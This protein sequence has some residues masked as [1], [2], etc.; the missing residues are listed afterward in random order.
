MCDRKR[1]MRSIAR[2]VGISFGAV[3]SIQIDT[4]DMS[5]A[6]ARWVTRMLTDDQKRRLGW[7]FLGLLFHYEDDPGDF[8]KRVV[9]LDETRVHHFDP[10]PKM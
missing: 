5:K 7:I 2:E 9:T 8:I 3:Q 10:K 6:S 4:L 1:D